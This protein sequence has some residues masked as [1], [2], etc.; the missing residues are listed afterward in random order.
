[1]GAPCWDTTYDRIWNTTCI[2][3]YT[4]QSSGSCFDSRSDICTD[5]DSA[6]DCALVGF[7]K[8]TYYN[9]SGLEAM[10]EAIESA[11]ITIDTSVCPCERA[12]D[13]YR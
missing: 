8:T 4:K 13:D 1:M 5:A 3:P 2:C 7:D 11:N 6:S 12:D 10:V 9:I